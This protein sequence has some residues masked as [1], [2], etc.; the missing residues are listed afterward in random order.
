MTDTSEA[1]RRLYDRFNF[2]LYIELGEQRMQ[3]D[4]HEKRLQAMRKE[5][6]HLKDTEWQY[7]PIEKHIGQA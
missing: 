5:C 7:D 6:D 3:V 4:N 2:Q 1:V